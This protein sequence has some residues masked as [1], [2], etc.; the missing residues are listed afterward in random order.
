MHELEQNVF[1]TSPLCLEVAAMA[2]Q[3]LEIVYFN[4]KFM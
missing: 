4:R 3:L 1:Y 2:L